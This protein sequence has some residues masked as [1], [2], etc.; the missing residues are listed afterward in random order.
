MLILTLFCGALGLP[1]Q[2]GV[3]VWGGSPKVR[4]TFIGGPYIKDY[5]ILGSILGAP[6]VG[7]LI[8]KELE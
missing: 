2:L 6:H 3:Y 4:G 7:E 5:N 1:K 8:H